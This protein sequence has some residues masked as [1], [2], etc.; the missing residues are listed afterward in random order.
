[1]SF[2]PS[3]AQSATVFMPCVYIALRCPNCGELRVALSTSPPSSEV[4]CPV[5]NKGCAFTLL[6]SGLTK[7]QLPFH[8]IPPAERIRWTKR[9]TE[10]TDGS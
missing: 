6:G 8:E 9:S 2:N 3:I 7:S 1:M 4:E 5:C 10:V